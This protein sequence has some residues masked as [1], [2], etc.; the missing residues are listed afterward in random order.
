MLLTN[1]G[2]FS[3]K[4]SIKQKKSKSTSEY[5]PS[6]F[7]KDQDGVIYVRQSSLVQV[8]NNI[9]SFEMQTDQFVEHFRNMGCTGNITIIA[10]DEAMSGTLDIHELPGLSKVVAMIEKEEIGWV[11][12][13]HINR[14]TRDPWLI[15]PAVLMKTCYDHDVWI[16][17]LRMPFNFKDDYCQ[18]VFMIEAE[19]SARHLEW[20]KLIL[21]GGKILSS[22][23]GYYDGRF[24]APGYIV[25]R[26]DLKRKKYIIY[27]PHA[28]IVHWLF[29]RFL[30]LDGN[31]PALCR[32]VAKL[33]YLF[34]KFE[35]WVD[36]KNINSYR[37]HNQKSLTL[38]GNYMV[39]RGGLISILTNPVY[40][41]WWLPIDGGVIED[42]H[43]PIVEEAL[44]TFAHK[45]LSTFDLNGERQKPERVSRNGKAEA[46]LK[47]VIASEP[48]CGVYPSASKQE[49]RCYAYEKAH[50]IEERFALAIT[51]VDP[52]FLEKFLEKL[53]TWEGCD[54]WE[55]K[56]E[57]MRETWQIKAKLIKKQL[58]EI[59]IRLQEIEDTLKTPG[60]PRNLKSKLFQDY[61]GLEAKK[62]ELDREL[63]ACPE[64]EL[65]DEAL[66]YQIDE[67][68]PLIVKK[69]SLLSYDIRMRI[70]NAL[71]RK[72]ILTNPAPGWWKM[73]IEWKREDWGVDT[74]QWRYD[75]NGGQH[76]ISD[77]EAILRAMYPT[78]DA[79]DILQAL[80]YR[81]WSAIRYRAHDQGIKRLRATENRIPVTNPIYEKV[82]WQDM[83]YAEREG[84]VLGTK[85]V[86]WFRR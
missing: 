85:N 82:C 11:G 77:E 25:D 7:P 61:E 9:H 44:F 36:K 48:G 32:E 42:N 51:R 21:G 65:S 41:G 43:E 17:T 12:A 63:R 45:R 84:L 71:T 29:Q 39:Y 40:I 49:Y 70:V 64:Q 55:D 24:I 47:K 73:E 1:S 72:V 22:K 78:E 20:M 3:M 19:E 27:A 2:E 66:L 86:Q 34:P 57:Q 74:G 18:R 54:D 6:E 83:E 62:Q 14:L 60:C 53:S 16:A 26:S 46:L 50:I 81:S 37:M 69:W 58:V 76:W 30:E 23:H 56:L 79:A 80:P 59:D 68:F 4:R 28:E 8:Q 10:D 31:F 38:E 33:P 15:K 13:V 52:V 75:S 35:D 67:L 5:N